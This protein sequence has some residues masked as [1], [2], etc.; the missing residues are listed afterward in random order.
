MADSSSGRVAETKRHS[1]LVGFLIR[2]VKEKPL[3]M[4]GGIITLLLL[5]TGIFADFIAPY[6]VNEVHMED[7]LA[8]PSATYW[9]GADNLGRDMLSRV[10]FGARVSVIAGLA[11]SIWAT[12]VS[13]IIGI[14][15]GYLGGKVDLIVQ[16]FVDAW[17]CLPSLILMMVIITII[18]TGL[19]QLIICMGLTFGVTGSRVIRSAVIGIKENVYVQAAEAIGCSTP[20]IL[21]RHIL[22]N[23]M[24]PTIVLLTTRV[25]NV[26][27]IEASL[28]FLGFGIP[29]PA[30]SWGGMLSGMGRFYMLRAWWMVVWPGLA[31]AI[32]VYGINMFGDAVRDLLDPRLRGGVG[33]YGVRV[34]KEAAIKK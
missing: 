14:L 18:G 25:P 24:A 27:L 32:V 34:K 30:A 22:P 6:G 7:Y 2:L 20:R 10:I 8:S 9:L 1:F 15:S 16:R 5:F 13:L 29:P 11:G 26:I 33:R 4:V 17:M 31:L 21:A 12:T 23:I 3:G 28:S 19:W